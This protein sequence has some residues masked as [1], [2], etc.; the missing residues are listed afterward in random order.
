M[1]KAMVAMLLKIDPENLG[2]GLQLAGGK[3]ATADGEM[4]LDFSSVLRINLGQS[5]RN[6]ESGWFSGREGY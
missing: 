5:Q 4:V 2:H 1:P 6:R 3:L